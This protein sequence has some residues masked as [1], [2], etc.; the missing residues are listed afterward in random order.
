MVP[1]SPS[2]P[3]SSH[4][5]PFR[6][7]AS[8]FHRAESLRNTLPAS[9]AHVEMKVCNVFAAMKKEGLNL[10]LFLDLIFWGHNGCTSNSTVVY[11]RS[12]FMNSPT[13][14]TVLSRWWS[15]PTRAAG[16][17]P[18]LQ[19]FA[20]D[21]TTSLLSQEITSLSSIL[22]PPPDGL[23]KK[24]L[25][26]INLRDIG[27]H[28]KSR[29]GAPH[30]WRLLE[31][32]ASTPR[33]QRENKVKDP[34]QVVLMNIVMMS[35]S[36]SSHVSRVNRWWSVYLKLCGLSARAFDA[37]HALGITMSHKWT[38]NAFMKI[39]NAAKAERMAAISDKPYFASHD[40]LNIPLRVFSQRLANKNHFIN[41]TAAT[42]WVLPKSAFDHL[43]PDLHSL[44]QTKRAEGY[45]TPF[46]MTEVALDISAEAASRLDA[47]A[48]S[49]ILRFL[50][51]SPAF[52]DYP[53]RSNPLLINTMN[54]PPVDLLACGHENAIEQHF[55]ETV[56]VDESSYNGTKQLFEKEF[57]S[58][59]GVFTEEHRRNMGRNRKIPWVGDQLSVDRTRGVQRH[60]HDDVNSFERLDW[61]ETQFGWFHALMATG[62]SLHKQYLGTSAG[63]GLRKAFDILGR[64]GLIKQ[65]TKGV[66]WHHLDEA[67]WHIGEANFLALWC[68]VGQVDSL[69]ELKSKSPHQILDNL[70][71]ILSQHTSY[72]AL[73]LARNQP[74]NQRDLVKEQMMMFSIDIL[75]YFDLREAIRCGDVGRMQDLLP[76]LLFRFSGG[77]NNKYAAEIL[78]LLQ[79]IHCEWPEPWKNYMIRHC[80]LINRT[81]KRDGF[82]PV[83]LG[84]EQN[85]RDI[86]VTWRSFGPGAN[87]DYIQKVSPAIPLLRAVRD[88]VRDQFS[89][90]LGRGTRH[91]TPSKDADVKKVLDMYLRSNMHKYQAER[92]SKDDPAADIVTRGADKMGTESTIKTWWV[93]RSLERSIEE[94]Y[95]DDIQDSDEEMDNTD[96]VETADMMAETADTAA[97]AV[98]VATTEDADADADVDADAAVTEDADK[99]VETTDAAATED[100]DSMDMD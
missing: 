68:T 35:Y 73:I 52:V 99:A 61:V 5:Y 34:F 69:D 84:Q 8:A 12:E 57:A 66:F 49:R 76:T 65:E 13:F 36:R 64:K 89:T 41:A 32:L 87:F 67:L 29:D 59:L 6:T 42:I 21:S 44:I 33:Q 7:P 81:G 45:K 88:S 78:E 17:Q 55:L 100:V 19:A 71:T 46:N 62:N 70:D 77:G 40:N 30:L 4:A 48:K 24:N 93:H 56:E 98:A 83:D 38:A 91:G 51:E 39:A 1:Q 85:I 58:Q 92:K 18:A 80:W 50:L 37:L 90:I 9:D 74:D 95:A 43:P 23:S 14:A 10:E 82:L 25:T 2:T 94:I 54:P 53:H 31:S 15:P 97:A 79:K 47:Q 11:E 75:P 72:T 60:R 26:D 20:V 16:H 86:K 27:E 63:I 96:G 22:S 3:S 28:V